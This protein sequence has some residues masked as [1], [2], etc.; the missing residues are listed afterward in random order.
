[1]NPYTDRTLTELSEA[2]TKKQLSSAELTRACLDEIEARDGEIGAFLTVCKETAP[3]AAAEID[4]RRL[5]GEALSPLAGIPAAL[6]DNICT[7]DVRTTCAS[8]MLERFVPPYDAFAWELLKNNGAV[9]LGKCNM[10]E[11]AMGS[12]TEHSALGTTRN[13]LDLSRVPG[14]SSGGPAA[15]VAAGMVPYAL[16]SDTG[17]SVRQPAAFC[18]LVGLKPT[19]GCVSRRG[20]VA[21]ASSLDQIGPLAKTVRDAAL[22][23]N[24]I[25]AHDLLDATSVGSGEDFTRE[26]GREIAG[27]RIAL[28]EEAF[29]DEIDPAVKQTVFAAA[30]KLE[31]LGAALVPVSMKE[32]ADAL[33]AYY[34][35]SSAEASSNLA[36]YDGVRYGY[37]STAGGD[38]DALYRA[39]RSEGFGAE[40]KRRIMLGT[41]ALSAGFYD[42]YYEKA[43]RV[44]ARVCGAFARV[45]NDCGLILTPTAPTTAF[46]IGEKQSPTALYAG[47][48]C[49]VP[50][51]IAGLP[52]L[53]VPCGSVGGLPVGV[54]LTGRAFGEALLCRVGT[55]LEEG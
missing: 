14:G 53:S 52:A 7:K 6:K 13:P 42:E 20:L 11:F 17:G 24:A 18:G 29:G 1:M 21:F 45:L 39:S 25:A 23:M 9:L 30:K 51:S 15:A 48:I 49:T 54:Q 32:L 28:P 27:V 43:S 40:V 3:W 33:P 37:R 50:A 4:R 10:D 12:S 41:F 5:A 8:R 16:G 46:R 22:V 55:A 35:L 38:I 31:A 47:D 26:I 2:L 19:Y 36:R 34:I 44:R